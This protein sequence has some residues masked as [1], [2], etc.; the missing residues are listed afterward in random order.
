MPVPSVVKGEELEQA[1]KKPQTYFSKIRGHG[2]VELHDSRLVGY[3]VI[4]NLPD[5][6][7]P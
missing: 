6:H 5:I 3:A 1:M 2:P 7:S 4:K